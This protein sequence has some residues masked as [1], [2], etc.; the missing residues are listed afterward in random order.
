MRPAIGSARLSTLLLLALFSVQNAM[1]APGDLLSTDRTNVNVRVSP[2]T[3]AGIVTRI[4]PGET[5]IEIGTLDDWL[6][7]RLPGQDREG[8]VYA[9]LMKPSVSL[10]TRPVNEQSAT[11]VIAEPEPERT[12]AVVRA[13]EPRASGSTDQRL[14]ARLDRFDENLVGD[15]RRGE[16]VFVKCGACHT[17]VPDIHADGPSLVGVFNN[18]PARSPGYRY[19]GAMQ[20]YAR[21][22]AVWDAATLDRFIQRP[23]RIVKG[24]SMPFSGLRDPQD[25]RDLIAFLEQ[26]SR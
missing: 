25:R 16:A 15:P 1:A 24:T 8:W 22:G 4:A 12:P 9:P 2:S 18:V 20:S 10:E 3:D 26:I 11:P 7:I 21:E 23:T 17:T 5:A 6:R 13:P 19:S 14:L